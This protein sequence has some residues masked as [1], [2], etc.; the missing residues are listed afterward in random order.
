MGFNRVRARLKRLSHSIIAKLLA[1][2]LIM[3]AVGFV[4][5]FTML[6]T[7][8][9]EDVSALSAAHQQS[10][11]DYAARDVE[12]KVR[13]R[14]ELLT[15]LANGLPITG[16]AGPQRLN[17]W[18]TERHA[19]LP[20]FSLGLHLVRVS[21]GAV[22]AT[23]RPE[24]DPIPIRASDWFKAVTATGKAY[25]GKPYRHGDDGTVV[26]T[27]AV[28]V[29]GE[30]G[31]VTAILTGTSAVNSPNFLY[32][33][34][35][36]KVG[37]TGG[38]LLI[39]PRDSLFITATDPE[40]VLK[41]VPPPGL[42]PLHDR[43]MAGFRG[44]GI[45]TNLKGVEEMSA[46]ASVPTPGWFLVARVPTAEALQPVEH[47]MTL[48]IRGSIA[49]SVTVITILLI[50]LPRL[51]RPLTQAARQLH[52]MARGDQEIRS[53]P[54]H[55]D[56][57]VGEVAK[58][59]NFL[60]G[61]LR[62]KEEA[63]RQSEARMTHLAHHDMLTGL[64]NRS[65][66]E[67]RLDQALMRGQRHG[68]GFALLYIDLDGFK[69]INDNK[70]HEAGDAMLCHVAHCLSGQLRQTDTVARIGGD[71][72][73]I[74]LTDLDDPITASVHIAEQCRAAASQPLILEDEPLRVDL[75]IGVACYPQDGRSAGEL[76]RHADHAMYRVK[77]RHKSVA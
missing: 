72:F 5:R 70:G 17:A 29:R 21:D 6:R 73:A 23:S 45:T 60:L 1:L 76:L 34:A 32:L 62:E 12:D 36:R 16:L 41:P 15:N 63:L 28:P 40:R 2:A 55:S 54:V 26:L 59:F 4:T 46:I 20:F 71:E 22:L 68:Q 44:T 42:N 31:A 61:V 48:V 56:D 52:R 53:L 64:P 43:A 66:F 51:F 8:L 14:L 27:M 19:A 24:H 33:L 3:V 77:S 38:F 37:E 47:I 39:D 13:L 18:L 75:S 65:M 49:V 10:I 9:T 67:D 57:E 7:I 30:N 35:E 50:M 11:A 25:I 69:P 74:L 58:G